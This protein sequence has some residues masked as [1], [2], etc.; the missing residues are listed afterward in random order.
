MDFGKVKNLFNF[1]VSN[2]NEIVL[3]EPNEYKRNFSYIKFNYSDDFIPNN[4]DELLNIYF[5]VLNNGWE[6][7][8]F[9]CPEQYTTCLDD[10][11]QVSSDNITLSNL[12]GYTHPFNNFKTLDTTIT[13]FGEITINVNKIYNNKEIETLNNKIIELNETLKLEHLNDR[14]KIVKIHNY[15][16]TNTKYDTQRAEN[17]TSIYSSD[18]AYGTLIEGFAV[19]SGYS[20]A[21]ALFL[22]Y[23]SIPNI[24]ISSHEHVWNLVYIENAWLHVDLTW[25][26]NDDSAIPRTNFLLINTEQL[27]SIDPNEHAFDNNFFIEAK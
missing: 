7:F 2:K 14:E 25:D 20:D 22:D 15:I 4:K 19:C 1:F 10:V 6:Q 16:I 26:D 23:F 21:L 24:K 17:K 13:T 12:N 8:M 9:Y 11:R 18:K 27:L 3:H 5:N